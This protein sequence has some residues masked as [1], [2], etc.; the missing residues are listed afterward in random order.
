MET[1]DLIQLS[2]L[3]CGFTVGMFIQPKTVIKFACILVAI[4]I[5]GLIVSAY[6]HSETFV[7]IFGLSCMAV[8]FVAGVALFGSL[9][10]PVIKEA[11]KKGKSE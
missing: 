1:K 4:C 5:F 6:L 10:T 7:W 2:A 11:F 8:P 9:L 3:I